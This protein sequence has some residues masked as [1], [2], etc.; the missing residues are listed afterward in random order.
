MFTAIISWLCL[1]NFCSFQCVPV[2]GLG[3]RRGSYM[4]KCK[5][6]FYFPDMNSPAPYFNG[7]SI[8]NEYERITKVIIIYHHT[9]SFVK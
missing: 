2:P 5:R 4:C 1:W 3:F 7:T 6:G 9:S 8:E